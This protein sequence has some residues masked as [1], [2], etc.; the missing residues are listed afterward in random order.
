[1]EQTPDAREFGKAILAPGYEEV[2]LSAAQ[3]RQ[4]YEKLT[5]NDQREVD[6]VAIGCP[7]LN[8][9][10]VA[11]VAKLLQGKKIKDGL[12]CWIHTNVATKAMAWQL[13][14]AQIIEASG[15]VLTQ[16]LCTVL[17]IPES[18]GLTSLATNSA[19]MA[20][21]APGSNKL[22]TWFGTM[23]NCI[24]AAVSGVWRA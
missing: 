5:S 10:Q 4:G 7:H 3:L 14:L 24:D 23:S 8:L 12:T 15:A 2:E 18:L 22:K 20:F 6:Y 19:K 16:D 1:M 9:N 21:Y 17:S 11:Q 13:G